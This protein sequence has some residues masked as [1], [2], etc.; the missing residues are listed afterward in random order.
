MTSTQIVY[1]EHSNYM[2]ST[3]IYMT[4]TQIV[5]DEHSN[6][7]Y[8]EHLHTNKRFAVVTIIHEIVTLSGTFVWH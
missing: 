7:I 2:T 1:D 3:Q 4:S 5:Y 8:D 6:C